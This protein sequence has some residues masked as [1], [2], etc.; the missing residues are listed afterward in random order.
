VN[1]KR[2]EK[3]TIDF[4]SEIRRKTFYPLTT[5]I[6]EEQGTVDLPSAHLCV[7]HVCGKPTSNI[8]EL[9]KI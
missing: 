6:L 2:N 9:L 4:I 7:G 8:D 5:I 3:K 1:G